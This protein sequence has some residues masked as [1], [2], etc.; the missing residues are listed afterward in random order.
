MNSKEY[1]DR[2]SDRWDSIRSGFFSEN[3][4]KK[5]VDAASLSPGAS[6]ADIGAGSGFITEELLTRGHHVIAVDQS[7]KM[8][9]AL[10][11][12]V[13]DR[14]SIDCRVGEDRSLPVAD[15]SVDAALANMFLHHVESPPDAIRE[16][17]R[18][19]KPG[20][21]VVLSDLDEHTFEFLRTEQHDRWMGFKR[22]DIRRWFAEAGLIDISVTSA[23]ETC[24]AS[25][26]CGGETAKV[27]IF[28]AAGTK[29]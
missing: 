10:R 29:K 14:G 3:L 27:T 17:A 21:R 23:E 26:E 15:S 20:G 22:D 12:R 16:M 2:I 5:A 4:G 9:L 7:E 28:L 24:C 1:F 8:L 11:T 13:G 19:V 25:S 18:I 6:V